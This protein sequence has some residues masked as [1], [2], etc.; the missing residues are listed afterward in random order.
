MIVN[1]SRTPIQITTNKNKKREEKFLHWLKICKEKNSL[2]Q[3]SNV[4]GIQTENFPLHMI[5]DSFKQDIDQYL[6]S[7]NKK[8]NFKWKIISCWVN[9]NHYCDFNMP[10]N[11]VSSG[12]PFSGIWYLKCPPDS[13]KLV[14]LNNT[15]NS[16]Y[17]TLF[18]FI[19]DPL[20]WVNYS[21]IPEQYQLILFPASLV[22]LV[23]PSRSKENRISVAF[24]IKLIK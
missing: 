7:F 15:N 17:S 20:S 5:K 8:F 22:H 14:F 10:H 9:E 1:I 18:D 23:E 3:I 16:D 12:I 2:R 21:I 19:D 11:H 6:N 13:G 24:N 4:G